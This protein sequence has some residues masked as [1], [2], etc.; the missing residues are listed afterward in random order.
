LKFPKIEEKLK[1][2]KE[3]ILTDVSSELAGI[4]YRGWEESIT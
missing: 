1:A 3:A 2:E 4:R